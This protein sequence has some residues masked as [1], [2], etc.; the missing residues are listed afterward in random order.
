VERPDKAMIIILAAF[1]LLL[2]G[3][4]IGLALGYYIDKRIDRK[5]KGLREWAK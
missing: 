4:C 1:W 5:V 3:I 2:G